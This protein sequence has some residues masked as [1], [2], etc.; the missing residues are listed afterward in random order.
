MDG[1]ARGFENGK[2]GRDDVADVHDGHHGVPSLL[3]RRMPPGREDYIETPARRDTV[4]GG[5]S[6]E[7][8]A[9]MV[10][11]EVATSH[12]TKTFDSANAAT[13]AVSSLDTS[14]AARICPELSLP[15][16]SLDTAS[17]R[18]ILIPGHASS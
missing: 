11:G 1:L 10:I 6:Q 2:R 5:I 14:P 16:F 12:S 3:R 7:G 4:G 15:E 17:G 13:G 9:E 18:S 8:R